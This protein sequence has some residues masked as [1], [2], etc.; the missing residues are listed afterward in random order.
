[1]SDA[2]APTRHRLLIWVGAA[3][4]A[5]LLAWGGW[6]RHVATW[7]PDRAAWPAHGVAVGAGNGPVNWPRLMRDGVSF[8]YIDAT[9]GADNG[10]AGYSREHD[11]AV[12]AGLPVGA[13]HHYDVC[14]AANDQAA[15][16]VRLVPREANAL[17]PVVTVDARA[18]C[19]RTPTRAL[20]LSELTT[21]LTQIETHVG[22][23]ALIDL[24]ATAGADY[25]IVGA[26]DRRLWLASNR[27]APGDEA[28]DWAIWLANDGYEA[29]GADGVVRLLVA[30]ES[31]GGDRQ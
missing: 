13:I 21:F 30:R 10:F 6:S 27:T 5:A 15:A 28:G 16:F 31:A 29:D 9:D 18:N 12:A 25:A 20:L 14:A 4:I 1:M 17:P 7:L 11:A 8:A 23:A 26:I 22:K 3:I 19:F 24:S 2:P